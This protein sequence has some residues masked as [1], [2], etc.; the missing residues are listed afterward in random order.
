LIYAILGF[1]VVCIVCLSI[2]FPFFCNV[3]A[4]MTASFFGG[5]LVGYFT[6]AKRRAAIT[7]TVFLLAS[8]I[9]GKIWGRLESAPYFTLLGVMIMFAVFGLLARNRNTE[10]NEEHVVVGDL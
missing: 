9:V 6:E 8:A 4:A 5:Y 7:V 2:P 1:F 10:A 3:I